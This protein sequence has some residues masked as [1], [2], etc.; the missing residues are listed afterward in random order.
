VGLTKGALAISLRALLSETIGGLDAAAARVRTIARSGAA[1]VHAL[2]TVGP[3]TVE[4][5]RDRLVELHAEV[6]AARRDLDPH[7]GSG[8]RGYV[9]AANTMLVRSIELLLPMSSNATTVILPPSA[10]SSK[11]LEPVLGTALEKVRT[12]SEDIVRRRMTHGGQT[13]FRMLRLCARGEQRLEHATPDMIDDVRAGILPLSQEHL[14][15]VEP[16]RAI[17]DHDGAMRSCLDGVE[18]IFVAGGRHLRPSV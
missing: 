13:V 9:G 7:A 12:L 6:E 14:D 16:F 2:E 17:T 5:S 3:S 8:L 4:R 15:L 1:L 11:P 10:A 18:A